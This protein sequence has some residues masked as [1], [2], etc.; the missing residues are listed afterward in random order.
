M[1][2]SSVKFIDNVELMNVIFET[3][4]LWK[5]ISGTIVELWRRLFCYLLLNFNFVYFDN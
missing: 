3:A 2:N 5:S 4:V 1:I